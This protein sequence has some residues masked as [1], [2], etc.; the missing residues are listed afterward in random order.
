M[1]LWE[2]GINKARREANKLLRRCGVE[3]ASHVNVEGFA[4]R[5]NLDVVDAPLRG[6]DGQLVVTSEHSSIILSDR[7]VNLERRRWVIAHELGHYVMEHASPPPEALLG[8]RPR[9]SGADLPDDEDEADCFAFAL[10]MPESTVRAVRQVRPMTLVAPARLAIDCGVSL[11]V[12]V[13]RLAESTDRACAAV[14]SGPSGIIWVAPSCRFVDVFGDVL[15]PGRALDRHSIAWRYFAGGTT[16]RKPE[17]VP[18]EAWLDGPSEP[19]ILEHSL[20][21]SEPGTL[22][23]MLWAPYRD[24]RRQPAARRPHT[25]A[26]AP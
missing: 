13:I 16:T 26:F 25:L 7:L 21:G 18:S 3:R 5:L 23:T 22:L 2:A 10:L 12:S 9:R 6:A 15:V 24:E 19:P 20:P 1:T 4:R 11:E 14:L 8:P 17:L